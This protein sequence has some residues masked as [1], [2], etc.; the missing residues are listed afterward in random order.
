MNFIQQAYKGENEWWKY[1]IALVV[2]M[3]PFILN[4]VLYLLLPE[5]FE[6]I[7]EDME[8]FQGNKNVFLLENLVPF[9]VL[10]AILLLFVRYLHKRSIVSLITSRLKIDWNRVIYSFVLWLAI[11]MAFLAI[12]FFT[13]SE[14]LIW[15]FK[16][17]PFFILVIISLVFLPLQTSFE[18]L[19][20]RGYLM[21]G[22]GILVKNRWFPLL[23]TSVLFGLLHGLNPEVEKLGYGVMVFYIGTGLLFGIVTLMDEGTEIALGLH[24]ANNI[25]AALF[26]TSSWAAFQTDAL[27]IDTSEPELDWTIFIPVFVVYPILIFILSR[28]YG[29]TNWSEK[30]FGKIVK[31]QITDE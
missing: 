14:N 11:S 10:L 17:I 20:F 26:I 24:A 16:P 31:P 25:V 22:I 8:N 5:I 9:V 19:L 27:Y 28:K 21:Q 6:K 1:L 18:E 13:D 7:Y 3:S 30:L 15:N 29:W 23:I 2:V 4:F 12:G